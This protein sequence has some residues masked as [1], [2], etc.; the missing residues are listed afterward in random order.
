[1]F[2]YMNGVNMNAKTNIKI[3][4][5]SLSATIRLLRLTIL[6]RPYRT[7]GLKIFS[8]ALTQLSYR[9][10]HQWNFTYTDSNVS[11]KLDSALIVLNIYRIIIASTILHLT[12]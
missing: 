8:L 2:A 6:L 10:T 9:S 1:M 11:R 4:N 7:R 5:H 12:N 3:R